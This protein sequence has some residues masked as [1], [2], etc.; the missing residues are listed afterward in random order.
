MA[1]GQGIRSW[2]AH[3][4]AEIAAARRAGADVI[5]L[6]AIFAT[7]SHPGS[8]PLGTLRAIALAR[9]AGRPVIALGGVNVKNFARLGPAFHGWAGIDAWL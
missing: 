5:F 3:D 8:R 2:P 9:H 6:S 7:R 1:R 4:L